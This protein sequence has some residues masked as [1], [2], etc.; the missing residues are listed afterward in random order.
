[1]VGALGVGAEFGLGIRPIDEEMR[2][3]MR[4]GKAPATWL[5]L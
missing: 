1:V 4:G 5:L 2:V 3:L